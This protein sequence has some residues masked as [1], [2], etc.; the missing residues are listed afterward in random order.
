MTPVLND[1]ERDIVLRL[2]TRRF[3]ETPFD[4][5]RLDV[6][7]RA[8][9]FWR[10]LDSREPEPSPD[11]DALHVATEPSQPRGDAYVHSPPSTKNTGCRR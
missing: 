10:A 4:P 2:W 6:L 11:D 7:E 9:S 1:D 5:Q 8:V 3:G